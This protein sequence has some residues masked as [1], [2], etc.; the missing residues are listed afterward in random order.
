MGCLWV[1]LRGIVHSALHSQIMA[2]MIGLDRARFL[3]GKTG[4]WGIFGRGIH[5]SSPVPTLSPLKERQRQGLSMFQ[6]ERKGGWT[7]NGSL[8]QHP[9]FSTRHPVF[10]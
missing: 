4:Y 10:A 7:I 1:Q 2:E 8:I 3:D 6:D 5:D 9:G